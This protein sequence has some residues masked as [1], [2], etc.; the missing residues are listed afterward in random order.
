M[1]EGVAFRSAAFGGFHK[2]DVMTYI[3]DSS[4]RYQEE[5]RRREAETEAVRE[6]LAQMQEENDALRSRI[7][8]LEAN[9]SKEA[10][11]AELKAACEAKLAEMR[12]SY[13]Q[14]LEVCQREAEGYRLMREKLGQIE[15]DARVH[16]I[17]VERE[18]DQR[19]SETISAAQEKHD[20]IIGSIRAEAEDL[21][22]RL[23]A[24]LGSV[25]NSFDNVHSGVSE[26]IAKA[27]GEVEHVRELLLDLNSCME[28]H[29]DSIHQIDVPELPEDVDA[30]EEATQEAPQ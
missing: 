6:Q 1:S 20:Q 9:A 15:I 18:A 25:C 14:E 16:A 3:S 17:T 2:K 7:A 26:S 8:K 10:E 21:R 5:I 29:S 19:A 13:Q 4:R 30:A 24:L 23:G 28:E 22:D 12:A 27:M 11:L